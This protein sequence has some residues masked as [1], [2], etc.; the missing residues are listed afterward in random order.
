MSLGKVNGTKLCWSLPKVCVSSKDTATA[1]PLATDY[2]T[3][4]TRYDYGK[5]YVCIT[6]TKMDTHHIFRSYIQHY[7]YNDT[8]FIAF[9]ST[10]NIHSPFILRLEKI[11]LATWTKERERKLAHVIWNLY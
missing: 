8:L 3:H 7:A 2:S 1:F 4:A 6:L 9:T 11:N 10:S 5:W